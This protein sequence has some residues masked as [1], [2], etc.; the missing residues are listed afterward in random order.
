MIDEEYRG[1]QQWSRDKQAIFTVAWISFL[2]AAVGTMVFFALFDPVDLGGIFDEDL[3]IGA[4]AGYAAGFF[5]FWVLCALC[6]GVTAYLVRTAPG[7][8]A[9]HRDQ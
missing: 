7:R 9:K 5:F 1:A 3:T 4:N 2:V 8:D 6:S